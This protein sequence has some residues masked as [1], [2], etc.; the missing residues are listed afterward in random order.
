MKS[1]FFHTL[2]DEENRRFYRG[3]SMLGTFCPGDYLTVEPVPLAAIRPGDVVVCRGREEVGEPDEIVH[4]VVAVAPG[5]LVT[6][7]DNSPCVDSVPVTGDTLLGRVTHVR[8]GVAHC[9]RLP[10]NPGSGVTHVRR[11]ERVL[12]VQSWCG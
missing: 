6:R 7:G 9:A 3:D 8:R 4:R 10:G 5:R 1:I 12:Q 11:Q 2:A